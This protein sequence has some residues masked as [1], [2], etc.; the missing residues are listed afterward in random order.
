[1]HLLGH[2]GLASAA[3]AAV[4]TSSPIAEKRAGA[5]HTVHQLP[6]TGFKARNGAAAMAQALGKYNA[7]I[8]DSLR[9]A[10]EPPNDGT[11][12]AIP[13]PFDVQYLSPVDIG[14]QVLNLVFDT[15]SSDLWVFSSSLPRASQTGHSVY[16][17]A[18][19]KTFQ[20]IDGATWSISYAD[21]SSA[22]GDVGTDV[23]NVGGTVV[24][25]QA[26]E[27]S[28]KLSA[29]FASGPN[30]GLLGLAFSKIN[31]VK[32]QR[33]KT[34]FDNASPTL[35]A[36]LFTA[37]LRPQAPGSYDFGFIDDG[38]YVGEINY[39]PISNAR[40]FWE[41]VS[42]GYKVG[43][44][45]FKRQSINAVADTGTTLFL[46]EPAI[47]ADY[48]SQVRGSRNDQ[49]QGGYVFPCSATLPDFTFAAGSYNARIPG[50]L[51]NF[52]PIDTA[53]R[54]CFGGIQGN[55]GLGISIFGDILFKSQFVVFDGGNNRLGFANKP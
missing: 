27:L 8:P 2:L 47:V 29:S 15:G 20:K 37:D 17:P 33:Q 40:G 7:T 48:Y 43:N 28:K 35:S 1:M 38:K 3:L 6:H 45:A 23:V 54:T 50:K 53:G 49:Q 21:G 52:A 11:E 18:K 14:G 34:F 39:T 36:P 42:S 10:A 25:Q 19:S 9:A 31:T 22:S 32:P 30:D 13:E 26:V 12:P 46:T 41:F 16:D 55:M 44:G 24:Q 5:G 4:A 51:I